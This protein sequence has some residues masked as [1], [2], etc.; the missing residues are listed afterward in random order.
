M[1]A[2]GSNSTANET[3]PKQ[4]DSASV[5]NVQT[6]ETTAPDSLVFTK[7]DSVAFYTACSEEEKLTVEYCNCVS[8]FGKASVECRTFIK[9]QQ[10][11]QKTSEKIMNKYYS[12][13]PVFDVLYGRIKELN[14]QFNACN[15]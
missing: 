10:P 14:K 1:Y 5:E 15:K 11:Y 3:A 7:E 2:C 4:D 6:V 12:N 9:Q 13:K 8:K